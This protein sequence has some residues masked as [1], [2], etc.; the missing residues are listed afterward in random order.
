MKI[1]ILFP[2]ISNIYGDTGNISYLKKCI[3]GVEIIKTNLGSKPSF[4]VDKID[5]VY[6]GSMTEKMQEKAIENLIKY[7]DEIKQK[8]DEKQ[9]I[10]LTGNASEIIGKH[11]ENEDG[12][13]VEGLDFANI[14][15]KR[16]MMHRYNTLVLAEFENIKLVGFKSQFSQIYG[17][18]ENN[19]FA[20][21]IRGTGINKESKLEG[22]RINNLIATTI[23]GPILVLNPLFTK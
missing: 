17:E 19:Y 22:I 9:A 3:P 21:I 2:E 15:A 18:N 1:E 20:K 12:T 6:L 14:Y 13:K 10:L 11:I 5:L 23:L 4:L 7:K 8:I 16:D